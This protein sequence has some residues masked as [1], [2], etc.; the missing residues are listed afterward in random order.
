M[1]RVGTITEGYVYGKYVSWLEL[2]QLLMGVFIES[3][4]HD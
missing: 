2:G 1:I 3:M 4:Y